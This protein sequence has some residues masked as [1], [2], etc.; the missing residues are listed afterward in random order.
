LFPRG[1]SIH[2]TRGSTRVAQES[3]LKLLEDGRIDPAIRAVMPL[4]Q[5]PEAH[6]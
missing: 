3:V 4:S 2:G 6:R 5:A 1:I